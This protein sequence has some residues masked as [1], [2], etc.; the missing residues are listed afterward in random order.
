VYMKGNGSETGQVSRLVAWDLLRIA[1]ITGCILQKYELWLL[2]FALYSPLWP[3]YTQCRYA[4][5]GI[6]CESGG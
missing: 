5:H 2:I 6:S 4:E 3:P 1:H